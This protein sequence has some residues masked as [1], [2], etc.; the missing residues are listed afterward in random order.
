MKT[1]SQTQITE[2][3]KWI[4]NQYDNTDLFYKCLAEISM[5]YAT[6]YVTLTEMNPSDGAQFIGK[7]E[8]LYVLSELMNIFKPE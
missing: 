4:S 7:R 8:D 1:L 3:N 2:L 6:M 5:A